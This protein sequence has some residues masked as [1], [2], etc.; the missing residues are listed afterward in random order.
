[1][2]TVRQTKVYRGPNIWARMPVVH[3]VVDIGELEDRPSNKIPGFYE[4]LTELLPSLY[5]HACSVGRPG[6]FLQRLREGTWMGHV[7]EHVALEL[8]NLAGGEVTRGKTRSTEE[9]GVYNV[10]YQYQQEDVGLAAG[11][12]AVRLLNHLIYGS[13]STSEPDFDFVRE[14]EGK[15]IRVAERLA[16]G[17]STGAIVSEAERRG[18]P[19]LRLDPRRSLVQLGHG[20]YQRRVW[21]T[22]TSETANIAVEVASNKELTNRL[23]H[24]VGIPVPRSTVVQTADEAVRAAERIGY[25]VVLKPLDGNHGRGVCINLGTEAEIREFFPVA[26]GE[27]R[28]GSV[29]VESFV[30]GKDYRILVVNNNVVAVAERVPAH[31]VGDGEHTVQQLIDATN[32][33]P[34]RGVGHEKILTRITVD[35]QTAEVLERQGMKLDDVPEPDRFV[36][37]KLTGNMSTGGTSIDRTDDIHPDNIEIARQAAM[38]VGLDIA[39][40]DF[41]TPD[42]SQSVR[43]A[44]GAIVEVN[45]GPGF[46][47]HTH[48][49]E[50]HP[51]HV[52]RAVVD[53]L[54]PPGQPFR[55][56]IVAVT[57]TNGKT[58]TCRMISHILKTSGRKVGLTTT[59]G[60]YIDGTQIMAGDTSGPT[61]AQMVLKNPAIDYAVL[62][63]ARGGIL[64]SGLGFDHCNIAVVTNVTSD[65]LGL[66]GVDTLAELARV[67]AVV[68]GAVLRDGA[69][70]LNADNQ[71]TVEMTRQARGEI[72]FFS[73]EEDNPVV[74][75]HIRERGRAVVLRQSRSGEMIT[76]I[77]HK[78]ETSLLLANQIP[79]TFDGR[80]RVNIANAMAAAAAAFAQD[81]Q[82]EY[83]RLALRTFTST[84]FQT[85]GRFNQLEVAG[86]RVILDYCHNIAGLES[87]ADFVKRVEAERTV[88][89]IAMPGDRS[90]GD[91]EAF[92]KLAGKTFDELVIREDTN[93]RGRRRGEVADLLFA[94]ATAG[95]IGHDRITIVHDELQAVDVAVEKGGKNDLVVLMVD[96]PTAVWSKLTGGRG[97]DGAE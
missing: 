33:D 46:R 5:D 30:R 27:T 93:T 56:P 26:H 23:L 78:R 18:I 3:L 62:E 7:L 53:M 21:A 67:K 12:L 42:I 92:G 85:P 57:G 15:V 84:F 11:E 41:I 63:T 10:V 37:L 47:M 64:R 76:F 54:F 71:W 49:T 50:G 88:G 69:T 48:P 8:Q 83:V 80:L 59:D 77:E 22:V 91:I 4:R 36:Q 96:K 14:L 90:N 2:L 97:D 58:T 70:V 40:I 43:Q 35:G 74:R 32:A 72:I 73:M 13:A 19:V 39:G 16:Y 61:S 38:V 94:A 52:G 24:E 31:V 55:V 95:G 20:R 81:L 75:N 89:L 9:R 68:P 44:N 60:I 29:V 82:L 51:R 45:A 79:A 28:S 6:G 65:H 1:V 25:P 34:R 86:R 66:G 17:P 87:M